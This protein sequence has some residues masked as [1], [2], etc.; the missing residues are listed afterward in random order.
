M[1]TSSGT[2]WRR[3]TRPGVLVV[4]AGIAALLFFGLVFVVLVSPAFVAFDEAGSG[5]FRSMDV[6]WFEPFFG[7]ATHVGD[8]WVM[9]FATAIAVAALHVR[10]SRVEAVMFG[11]TMMLGTSVGWLAKELV[12]R[13]RPGLEYARITLPDSYSFPSGHALAT[14]LFFALIAFIVSLE[15]KSLRTRAIVFTISVAIPLLVGASRVYLGVHWFG[16]VTA[17]WIL[18]VGI[19][20]AAASLYFNFT[21]TE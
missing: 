11:L 2:P 16:D 3:D 7:A 8:F 13:S 6:V 21:P 14:F 15:A 10:G 12:E 19:M 5:L 9:F 18:G 1:T 4:L 17:S 20:A